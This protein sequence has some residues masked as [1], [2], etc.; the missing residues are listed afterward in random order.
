MIFMLLKKKFM[1]ENNKDIIVEVTQEQYAKQLAEGFKE[2]EILSP[3]F[4]NFGAVAFANVTRI[5]I[6][7]IAKFASRLI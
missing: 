4:I 5:L 3:V 2:D 1:S 6:P 7:M